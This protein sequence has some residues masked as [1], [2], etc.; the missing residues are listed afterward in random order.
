MGGNEI[1][2]T[3]SGTV[4]ERIRHELPAGRVAITRQVEKILVQ[5]LDDR[6]DGKEALKRLKNLKAGK[7]KASPSNEVYDRLGI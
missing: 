6:D 7:T 1:E 2:I 4:A 3:L 5:W